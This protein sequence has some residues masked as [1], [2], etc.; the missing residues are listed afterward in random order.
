MDDV[1]G[2]IF[3]VDVNDVDEVNEFDDYVGDVQIMVIMLNDEEMMM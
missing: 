3:D 1:F 2:S